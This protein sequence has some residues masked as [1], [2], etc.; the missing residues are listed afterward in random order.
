MMK[1]IYQS[2]SNNEQ[3]ELT[4]IIANILEEDGQIKRVH[5]TKDVIFFERAEA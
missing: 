3:L 1:F 5:E 2:R 4:H